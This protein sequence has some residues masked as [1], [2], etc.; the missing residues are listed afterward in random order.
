MWILV[1]KAKKILG[2]SIVDDNE[3]Y[4]ERPIEKQIAF[5]DDS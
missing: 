2:T 5:D 4:R 3:V 1:V